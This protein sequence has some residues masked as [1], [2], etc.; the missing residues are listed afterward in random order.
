MEK[1]DAI[2]RAM[3]QTTRYQLPEGFTPKLMKRVHERKRRRETLRDSAYLLGGMACFA[4]LIAGIVAARAE[5]ERSAP[6]L[7]LEMPKLPELRLPEIDF[8]NQSQ[9]LTWLLMAVGFVALSLCDI[10]LR[11]RLK[12]NT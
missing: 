1:N 3:R 6:H 2:R 7:P 11:R 12:R 8:A 9:L 5:Y 10:L 4:A